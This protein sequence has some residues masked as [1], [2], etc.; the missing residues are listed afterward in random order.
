[1]TWLIHYSCSLLTT[2]LIDFLQ[3]CLYCWSF[4]S[5]GGPFWL[6]PTVFIFCLSSHCCFWFLVKNFFFTSIVTFSCSRCHLDIYRIVNLL[7]Q[8]FFPA[9]GIAI[10][11]EWACCS[12]TWCF[13]SLQIEAC[14]IYFFYFFQFLYQFL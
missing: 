4:I 7:L 9:T 8:C 6:A 10:S 3:N 11:S 12:N 2:N 1:M 14:L 13:I 5:A